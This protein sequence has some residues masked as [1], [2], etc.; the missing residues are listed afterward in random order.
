MPEQAAVKKAEAAPDVAKDKAGGVVA[1][2]ESG[3]GISSALP[4]ML[5][6]GIGV[7]AGGG[8]IAPSAFLSL[9]RRAGNAALSSL[10]V[11]R[12]A[13]PQQP[14]RPDEELIKEGIDNQSASTIKEVRDFNKASHRDKILMIDILTDQIWVDP[15]AET[16]LEKIWGTFGTKVLEVA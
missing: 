6:S 11:Q 4:A 16:A 12:V 2:A 8:R 15:G 3:S 7:A 10:L 1:A 14:R 5:R 13:V 9:Q